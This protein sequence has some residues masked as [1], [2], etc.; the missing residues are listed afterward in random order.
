MTGSTTD[1]VMPLSEPHSL[2]LPPALI[3][4][5][6]QLKLKWFAVLLMYLVQPAD[7]TQA[8]ARHGSSYCIQ[9]ADTLPTCATAQ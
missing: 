4:D 1:D 9:K 7:T 2:M 8:S 3:T 6:A 5:P